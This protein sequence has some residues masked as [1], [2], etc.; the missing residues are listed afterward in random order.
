MQPDRSN[1]LRA[2]LAQRDR[3][4]ARRINEKTRALV[5]ANPNNPTGAVC[6]RETL[7]GILALAA[8][9]GLV[10]FSDE[11]YNKL[12]LDPLECVSIASLAPDLPVVTFNGL[13]K[14][15]LVPGFRIGWGIL[16][17]EE[18]SVAGYREA[19]AKMLR[20]RLSAN[21]PAQFA[22]RPALEGNQEHIA[23]MVEKLRRRRD[24]AVSLLNSFPNVR[25]FSPQAAFY[26]FPRL[27]IGR[28]DWEFVLDL[29]RETGVMV[30]PGA[31]FGES[32][33]TRHFRLVFLPPEKTL[34]EAIERI[35]SFARN[36]K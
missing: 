9:H 27:E 4:I 14:A 20:V 16:S 15:Y 24:R 3:Y 28:S 34:Q 30:V 6:R 19:I 25:C 26:A 22:V 33:G 12:L 36:W 1:E 2:L 5:V 23:D 10:I 35:G 13:S 21:H 31:G 32:P 8:R 11:I 18:R 7:S 17:G 29:I